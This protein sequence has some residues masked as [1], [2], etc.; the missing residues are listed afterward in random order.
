VRSA[1]RNVVIG[2]RRYMVDGDVITAIDGQKVSTWNEL[3]GYLEDNTKIGQ[4]VTLTLVRD[5][6][7]MQLTATLQDTP[8]SLR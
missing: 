4:Q 3:T 6:R 8:E 5:G 7:E 1:Q 2:N